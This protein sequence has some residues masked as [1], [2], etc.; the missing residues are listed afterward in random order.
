[1]RRI[2]TDPSHTG[3]LT[4][5]E[6][7]KPDPFPHQSLIQITQYSLNRGE[8]AMAQTAAKGRPIGWDYVGTIAQTAADGSGL[9]VGTRVVGWRPEMD[10]F[11]EY[12]IGNPRYFA[13]IPDKVTDAQAATLPVAGLT[14]LAAIDKGTRLVGSSVLVNG[15]TGGVGFFALQLAK[16]SGARVVAQVRKPEQ[17]SFAQSMGADAVVVT[18]DGTGLETEGPY[19]LVLD[20][21][22]GSLFPKLL[23]NTAKGGTLVSY[24]ASGGYDIQFSPHPGLFGNGGQR[25]VYGLTLYTEVE[26]QP[27]SEGL[28][29]LLRL[30]AKEKLQVP[31]IVEA[32]WSETPRYAQDLLDRKFAGKAVMTVS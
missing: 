9:P 20:G 13:P 21:V 27:S 30:V 4:F 18:T 17:V 23:E 24:G 3:S 8:I 10:A 15:I 29:R 12:V 7:K 22:S 25:T 2:I 31:T 26:L 32:D 14:A 16:L 11:A 28:A 6:A 5:G 19:R 1:M